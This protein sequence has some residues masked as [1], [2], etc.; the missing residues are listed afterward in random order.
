REDVAGR[1][2]EH[3]S[4]AKCPGASSACADDGHWGRLQVV[5]LRPAIQG[6]EDRHQVPGVGARL[7]FYA[8]R[9]L[10]EGLPCQKPSV[11]ELLE[12]PGGGVRADA[13][14]DLEVLETHRPVVVQRDVQDV[15]DVGGAKEMEEIF[16][17]ACLLGGAA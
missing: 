11:D 10:V 8:R 6:L 15:Q 4:S 13:K 2:A 12:P 16:E 3:P 1:W 14:R 17:L 9:D 5:L 7:V